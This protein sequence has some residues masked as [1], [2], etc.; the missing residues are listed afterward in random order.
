MSSLTSI[1]ESTPEGFRALLLRHMP[2]EYGAWSLS[3][4]KEYD[5]L[6]YTRQRS[7]IARAVR[8]LPVR[9]R[10]PSNMC[11]V[12]RDAGGVSLT[13]IAIDQSRLDVA[14]ECREPELNPLFDQLIDLIARLEPENTPIQRHTVEQIPEPELPAY[15]RQ[16]DKWRETWQ[17]IQKFRLENSPVNKTANWLRANRR[18]LPHSRETVSKI[19]TAGKAGKL[20]A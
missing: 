1:I 4:L 5:L 3:T 9:Y 13:W 16:R 2:Q 17:V 10:T 15:Q 14:A 20:D 19:I 11:K 18:H 6:I 7:D 12:I 8:T